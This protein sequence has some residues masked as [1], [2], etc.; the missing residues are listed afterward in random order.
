MPV[1]LKFLSCRQYKPNGQVPV[2]QNRGLSNE[3]DSVKSFQ[4]D[5]NL[6]L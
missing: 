1:V 5:T 2:L 6:F 3:E 4:N